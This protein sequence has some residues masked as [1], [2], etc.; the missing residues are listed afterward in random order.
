V[1]RERVRILGDGRL[2]ERRKENGG[3]GH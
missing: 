3:N 2:H 1:D